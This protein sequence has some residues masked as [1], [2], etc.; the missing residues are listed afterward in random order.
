M[1]Q[2]YIFLSSDVQLVMFGLAVRV[3]TLFQMLL[4]AGRANG[5]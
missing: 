3:I 4:R 5:A 1:K 2:S